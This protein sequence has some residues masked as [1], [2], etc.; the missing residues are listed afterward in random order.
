[1]NREQIE[2]LAID[3]S[4]KQINEDAEALLHEYLSEHQ[5]AKQW[6]LEMQ[7]IYNN[8]QIVFDKKTSFAK[9][10]IE[11]KHVFK[12][13]QFPI[14]RWAAVIIVTA[15]VGAAVGR[16]TKTE[17]PQQ[18]QI[19]VTSSGN[20]ITKSPFVRYQNIGEGFWSKKIVA[21]LDSSPAKIDKSS[22]A[23]PS[24]W[25]KYNKYIKEKNHE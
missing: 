10:P 1:M 15:C 17:I 9:Q 16:W 12:Y 18:K 3:F 2:K 11:N 25:E 24:L 5:E 4:A 20:F 22:F 6:F 19:Q 7:E 21:M 13:N 8:T 14:L 23:G